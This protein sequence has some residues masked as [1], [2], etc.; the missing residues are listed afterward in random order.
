MIKKYKKAW[1]YVVGKVEGDA[2]A[3]G[4]TD[5]DKKTITINK[6]YHKSKWNH[7]SIRKNKDGTA[8]ITDTIAHELMHKRHPKMWEKTVRKRTRKAM[9]KM[10]RKQKKKL[11]SKF[12][13]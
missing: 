8:N 13:K 7:K 3:Y 5:F 4:A 12:N 1:K 2:K 11:L 10:G 9:K 6:K